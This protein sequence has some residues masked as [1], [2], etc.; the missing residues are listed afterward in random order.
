MLLLTYRSDELHRRH[1]LLP[2]LAELERTGRVERL[3]LRPFDRARVGRAARGR[4]RDA[5]VD[6]GADRVDPRAVGRQRL[7]RRGA[8]RRPPARTADRAALDA[9]RRAAGPGRRP[10]RA[11]PGVPAGRLGGGAAG[12]PGAARGRRRPRRDA[13]LRGAPRVRR[14]ARSSCPTRRPASSATR[15]ATRCSRRRSTTTCCRASGPA[16]TRRSRGPSRPRPPATRPTPPSSPTTGTPPTTCRA[17]SRRRSPRPS[18]RGGELRVP[19]GPRP[20][21]ARD[22]AVGPGARRGSARR[23]ATGSTCSRA[24]AGVA[25]FHEP[26]RAVTHIQAAIRLVDE[27]T[28]TRSAA[29]SCTSGSA[30]TPGSPARATSR[31]EAYAHG[32]APH[33]GR[34]AVGGAGAC[35]RGLAQILMLGGR[36]AESTGLAEEALASR[37]PSAPATSRVMPRTRAVSTGPWPARSRRRST[38]SARRSPSP[39]RSASSTT[40]A[41]PTR[42]GSGSSTSPAGSRRR[43]SSREIGIA[44]VG[45]ARADA[46]LRDAPALRRGRRPVPPRPVGRSERAVRRA[47]EVGPLGI[48]EILVEELLG[49][50]GRGPRPVRGGRRPPAAPRAARRARRR[51]PVRRARSRRASRSSRSGRAGRTRPSAQVAAP[52]SG[53][54]TSRPRSRIGELYALGLRAHADAA[55]LARARR[56]PSGATIGRGRRGAARGDPPPPRRGPRDPAGLRADV[57]GVAP[58]VRGGGVA[59]P[60]ASRPRG[61]GAAGRGV[62]AARAPVR[63]RLRPLAGG[64]GAARRSRR[65]RTGRRGAPGGARHRGSAGCRAA[66]SRGDGARRAGAAGRSNPADRRA[67]AATG[68][69]PTRRQASG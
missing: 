27:A 55:E 65:P 53:S 4:S 38:T 17:R 25:R 41:A 20:L 45:A 54:S 10:H 21:R 62:G 43:S 57:R 69:D 22:R 24:L 58:A 18:R 47:E 2:F 30:A 37:G 40:S 26:A 51:H 67:D 5:I 33:P 28:P 12:R 35:R 64:R 29:A 9:A 60:P 31:S 63:R 44:I 42:T 32:H 66:R 1:P 36:F 16:C 7:L 14:H 3:E 23:D 48:N 39:R 19:G 8:A 34:A 11:D 49:A 52:R 46:L 6:A 59:A 61:L 15:S 56:R 68:R 50:P 13:A